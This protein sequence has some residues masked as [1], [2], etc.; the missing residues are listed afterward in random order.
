MNSEIKVY[1]KKPEDFFPKVEVAATYVNLNGKVL[2]LKLAP[3]KQEAGAWGV[4]AGKLESH[5]M[6][7]NG[8]KRELFEETGVDISLNNFQSLGTLY[9]RKPDIDYIYHL[10]SVSLNT[11]PSICLSTEHSS[12]QWVS[13]SESKNLPLMNGA[14]QALDAYIRSSSK[15]GRSGT[16]VNVY[17]ILRKEEA[18]LLH[19]R[20]NTGY[21]D[22][23]YGLVAGHVEDGESAIAAMIREANEE[24]GISIQSSDLQAVHVMH[25]Q[26]NRFNIDLFFEC[27][28]WQGTLTN[29]E[30]Q[31]CSALECFPLSQLPLNTIDYI[32]HAL[33]AT[34]NDNFYSEYGWNT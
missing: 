14:H 8:A 24:A 16:S 20:R 23:Y 21:C 7:V 30:P 4:P 32:R 10:F 9:I 26:T 29:R 33:E 22:G 17:L 2:F 13:P 3:N 11:Q 28:K 19:L 1:E 27:W 12:Y 15:K 34:L 25:R 18:V 6:P 31:K 5:E